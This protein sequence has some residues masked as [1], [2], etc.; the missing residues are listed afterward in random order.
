MGKNEKRGNGVY[1]GEDFFKKILSTWKRGMLSQ[2]GREILIKAVA[3][4][5]PIYTMQ[6]FKVPKKVCDEIN[7]AMVGF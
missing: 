3:Y 2:G 4:A 6:C 5:I 1:E 7:G